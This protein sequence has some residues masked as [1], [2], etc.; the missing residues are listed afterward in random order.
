MA[1]AFNLTLS[2][3]T[4]ADLRNK[5]FGI[6]IAA[7]PDQPNFAHA[8]GLAESGL[9]KGLLVYVYCIDEAVRGVADGRLQDLKTRGLNLFACAY[10][11]QQR[12][13]PV[14]EDAAFAGLTVVSDL[15][16]ATDRF[17]SFN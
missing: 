11:A 13:I 6:L 2:Q 4:M 7:A 16:A 1:W 15:I 8:L 5:K 17:V 10:S 12:Q 14:T 3:L 9:K